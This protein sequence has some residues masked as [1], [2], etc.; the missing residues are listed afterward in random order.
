MDVW[1]C[2]R[3]VRLNNCSS[4]FVYNGMVGVLYTVN[5]GVNLKSARSRRHIQN[6]LLPASQPSCFMLEYASTVVILL[7]QEDKPLQSFTDTTTD[8]HTTSYRPH[9]LHGYIYIDPTFYIIYI[10]CYRL[11]ICTHF[12]LKVFMDTHKFILFIFPLVT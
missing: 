3:N 7:C 2:W 8:T 11:G 12:I 1:Q 10:Q 9:V 6:P 4:P 5:D